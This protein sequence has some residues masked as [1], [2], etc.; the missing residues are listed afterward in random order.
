VIASI[1]LLM[2]ILAVVLAWWKFGRDIL[3]AHVLRSL[4][5]QVL[6][7]FRIYGQIL[8]GRTA[9]VWIRTDRGK[10]D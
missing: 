9:A 6:R 2:F 7:K 5:P 4:G 1:N 3:P 10:S 8:L